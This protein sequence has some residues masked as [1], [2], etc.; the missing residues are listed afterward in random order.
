MG[1]ARRRD[2]AGSSLSVLINSI[3]VS[4]RRVR[5]IVSWLP[6]S[7]KSNPFKISICNAH[8]IREPHNRFVIGQRQC[9]S[10][11]DGRNAGPFLNSVRNKVIGAEFLREYADPD[12]PRIVRWVVGALK[13][14]GKGLC[15]ATAVR[16]RR[17]AAYGSRP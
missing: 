13:S 10:R 11:C 5:L 2:R 6:S 7:Y 14:V 1:D 8:G 4:V 15:Q 3:V 17:F 16:L 12:P 9:V